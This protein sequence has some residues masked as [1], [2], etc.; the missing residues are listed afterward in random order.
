MTEAAADPFFRDLPAFSNFDGV[1]ELGN[2]R[3]LPAGWWLATA[4]IVDS[5]GAVE[6][7]RYKAVNMAGASVISAILNTLGQHDLPYV[8]GG[9]GATVAVPPDRADAARSALAETRRWVSE[10]MRLDL[11]AAMVPI[12]AVRAAGRDVLVARYAVNDFVSY[13]MFA[14]GGAAWAEACMKAG[15]FL[16]PPAAPG[17]RPDL[18]GL[19]CRWSPIR[20]RHGEIVSIIALPVI[21]A[22]GMTP[23]RALIADIVAL[24]AGEEREG[25]P[26]AEEG[27]T[28]GFSAAGFDVEARAIAPKGGRR[29]RHRL[30]ILGEIAL[31]VTLVALRASVG[32]FD[33]RT[34]RSDVAAN[35]DF[36][37]FDD[38]LKMT[39]DIAPERLARIEDRLETARRAGIC[40]YGLHRQDTALMTCVVPSPLSRDHVHFIDG[41][42]G[43]YAIAARRLKRSMAEV[44]PL[45]S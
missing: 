35:S 38:G 23:F 37:K 20:A 13:A 2:Y 12:E 45:A 18:T 16:V 33:A 6:A 40:H 8:F 22:D 10:E 5:T 34:Y 43:G 31:T 1:T 28:L 19:S 29:F 9:D 42:A 11:R 14:G 39:L 21:G 26:V 27:P 24:A 30:R 17:A 4:D 36:R 32:R 44:K 3:P 25:H 7:G 15:D 41:A